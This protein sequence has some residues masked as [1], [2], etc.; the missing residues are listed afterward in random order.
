MSAVLAP[1][2]PRL[3]LLEPPRR[4]ME[5]ATVV[6][7]VRPLG[8]RPSSGGSLEPVRECSPDVSLRRACWG[9]VP[10]HP[11]CSKPSRVVFGE[12]LVLDASSLEPRSSPTP[13]SLLMP[14]TLPAWLVGLLPPVLPWPNR[15]I[16]QAMHNTQ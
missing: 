10:I 2:R 13:K 15:F 9:P 16:H 8:A 3:M 1:L 4:F 11:F 14:S 6:E 12:T 5:A 7:V